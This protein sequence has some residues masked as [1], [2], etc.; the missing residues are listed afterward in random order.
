[1][2]SCT[3]FFAWRFDGGSGGV[4]DIRYL[5][6]NITMDTSTSYMEAMNMPMGEIMAMCDAINEISEERRK[7]IDEQK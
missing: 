7:F 1:M 4:D 5:C 6:A 2:W 3:D